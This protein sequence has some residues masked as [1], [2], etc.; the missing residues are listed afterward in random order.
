MNCIK[1]GAPISEGEKFC[2]ACGEAVAS[3]VDETPEVQ[4]VVLKEKTVEEPVA[5]VNA[6]STTGE[7]ANDNF[8]QVDFE[9]LGKKKKWLPILISVVAVITAA[10]ILV[11]AFF[12]QIKGFYLKNFG[13]AEDYFKY[14]ELQ[15]LKNYAHDFTDIYG[16]LIGN[17]GEDTAAETEIKLNVSEE[18]LDT[19]KTYT[20]AEIDLDWLNDIVIKNNSNIK[21]NIYSNKVGL[22]ISG[23]KIIDL[24]TILNMEKQEAFI[25]ILTLSDKYLKV[26][27]D[28]SE[29]PEQ[30][31]EI[32]TNGE[33]LEVMPSEEELDALID[34]YLEIAI[35]NIDDVEKSKDTIEVDDIEQKVTVLEI[36]IDEKTAAK[37][38]KD[39]LKEAK[40]DKDIKKIIDDVAEYL[41]D[42]ELIDDADE[43]YDDYK[44]G[45]EEL[46][47]SLDKEEYD[48]EQKLTIIDYVDNSHKVIGR[49]IEFD[50]EEIISYVTAKDGDEFA[51]KLVCQDVVIKGDG[52]EK[53][54]VIN[55]KYSIIVDKKEYLEFTVTD[56]N[57]SKIDDGIIKGKILIKPT[58]KA[59]EELDLENTVSSTFGLLDLGLELDFET[60]ED[61]A[62][63]S[64]NIVSKNKTLFG[65]SINSKEKEPQT[66]KLPDDDKTYE[67]DDAEEWASELDLTKITDALK[68]AGVP[69]E[70]V[71]VLEYSIGGSYSDDYYDDYNDTYDDYYGEW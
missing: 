64:V 11:G 39:V 49:T 12:N 3:F 65:I 38:A 8:A 26:L 25:G 37:I 23:K 9:N 22:E 69:E 60:T 10:A 55:G 53:K 52:T 56:Y 20:G 5:E 68:K 24:S 59:L 67:I 32:L 40:K 57:D 48:N 27:N 34:K 54:D 19:L 71:N 66:V 17:Y 7:P 43:V 6:D 30:Y 51:T 41:E 50:G 44:D 21:D 58:K 31:K 15:E 45:I 63:L 35:D 62:K 18:A 42:I 36:E 46:L 29:I 1:C 28:E 47:D 61:T 13:N 4:E 16:K 14:V 70:L 33:Y 2:S